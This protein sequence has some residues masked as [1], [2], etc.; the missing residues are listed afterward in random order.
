MTQSS[1][2]GSGSRNWLLVLSCVVA[3]G[4]KGA[5]GAPR[6][7]V[8]LPPAREPQGSSRA[9]AAATV[10][11]PRC[12]S[13]PAR[14]VFAHAQPMPRSF[15][16]R[17]FQP[18]IAMSPDSRLLATPGIEGAIVVYDLATGSVRGE[19]L[20]HRGEVRAVA[21]LDATTLASAGVDGI[22]RVWDLTREG[23]SV[24]ADL[25][26][27][28]TALAASPRDGTMVV[29]AK[30]GKLRWLARSGG[31]PRV[32]EGHR[33]VVYRVAF[34]PDGGE[35]ASVGADGMVYA[36]QA[37]GSQRQPRYNLAGHLPRCSLAFRPG[38]HQ[39]A[40]A[41]LGETILL[42]GP[43]RQ[44]TRLSAWSDKIGTA[45]NTPGDVAFAFSGDGLQLAV[46][47]R[48]WA[49]DT[50]FGIADVVR[51]R[52]WFMGDAS[53]LPCPVATAWSADGRRVARMGC[54][55]SVTLFD[56]VARRTTGG[57][58]PPFDNLS[59]G[60]PLH[61]A[62]KEVRADLE[63]RVALAASGTFAAERDAACETLRTRVDP[64]GT[65]AFA[66]A[67]GLAFSGQGDGSVRVYSTQLRKWQS[68]YAP[69]LA[70][71]TFR[72]VRRVAASPDG[73][74]VASWADD[75]SIVV[76]SAAPPHATLL[77]RRGIG[78]VTRIGW[79]ADGR[80]V[81]VWSTAALR[82]LRMADGAMLRVEDGVA[83]DDGGTFE[84]LPDAPVVD[85]QGIAS[86]QGAAQ[87]R[88][89][90]RVRVGDFAT[91]DLATLEQA[92]TLEQRGLARAFFAGAAPT[93][94]ALAF[95]PPSP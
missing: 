18:V 38:T 21:F 16:H 22:V 31:P 65:G 81:A 28:L 62:T 86:P 36:F 2:P 33:G 45:G 11:A 52:G 87:V 37:D 55:H 32:V 84:L 14:L 91:G 35:V 42:L 67:A 73:L 8:P 13:R 70:R 15:A 26:V 5:E 61:H 66:C 12:A 39:I 74:R 54:D 9:P 85:S 47:T 44:I 23:P 1:S 63:D 40:L 59:S 27:E 89:K 95:C 49:T 71:A 43:D 78:G 58:A 77:Q 3:A 19:L 93:T 57:R 60:Y 6:Y 69:H 10:E 20:Q 24:E 94:G 90:L 80:F 46:Q 50:N 76:A 88:A 68:S 4:C 25:G 64:D 30:D 48:A 51:D 72:Q 75:G 53:D 56:P 92:A 7:D 82:V 34:H 41:E 29:G 79:S 83:S 17:L